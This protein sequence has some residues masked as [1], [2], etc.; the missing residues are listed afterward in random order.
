MESEHQHKILVVDGDNKNAKTFD[1]VFQAKKF[2]HVFIN[3]G[4][5]ALEEIKKAE[6]PFSVIIADQSIEG[7]TWTQILEYAQ[8]TTPD[9]IRVLMT[10]HS[11][12]DTIINAVN[13]G[14]VQNFIVK[15]WTEDDLARTVMSS[16]NLYNL[17]FEEKKRLK[18]AKGQN[19][20]LYELNCQLVETTK[21]NN[22]AIH[23]L[24]NEIAAL[25]QEIKDLSMKTPDNSSLAPEQIIDGIKTHVK[26]DQGIDPEKTATLFKDTIKMLYGQFNEI[27]HRNGFEMPDM[28][29]E[30]K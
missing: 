29:G 12:V 4:N 27:S 9:T 14:A 5:L 26:N 19:K 11:Q 21:S 25:N 7:M 15:P 20:Q 22:E 3:S 13:K 2:D 6:K 1:N 23:E 17:F 10:S 24:D 30:I 28:K 18:L 16:I 8:K